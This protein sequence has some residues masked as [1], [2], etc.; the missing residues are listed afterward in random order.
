MLPTKTPPPPEVSPEQAAQ[1]QHWAAQPITQLLVKQL[2][3]ETARNID[4]VVDNFEAYTELQLKT[5]L[6]RIK[7]QRNILIC[8]TQPLPPQLLPK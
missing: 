2:R 1:F 8:L 5:A 6:Q 7:T 4:Q 3:A